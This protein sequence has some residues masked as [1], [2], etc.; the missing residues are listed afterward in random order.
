M[1]LIGFMGT[2]KTAVGSLLAEKLNRQFIELDWMI[3]KDAGK[4]IP[5][6]FRNGGEIAFREYEIAAAKKATEKNRSIIACGGGMVL[7]KINVDRLKQSG[8]IFC[9]TASPSVILERTQSQAGT[10]PL[11][12]VADPAK[13]IRELV[14]YRKPYYDRAADY[15]VNTTGKNIQEVAQEITDILEKDESF[16]R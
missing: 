7:N 5:E 12:N 10:R 14:T 8:I 15:T 2:G 3:E 11:L 4:P 6:I 1:V 13:E 9:L 16:D